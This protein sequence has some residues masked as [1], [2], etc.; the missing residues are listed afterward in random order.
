MCLVTL[1]SLLEVEPAW[2]CSLPGWMLAELMEPL[3][4]P[5]RLT[6]CFCLPTVTVTTAH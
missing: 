3:V 4:M 1:P 6:V 5:V 2:V